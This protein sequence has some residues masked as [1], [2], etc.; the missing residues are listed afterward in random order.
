[1]SRK[2][3]K[4]RDSQPQ[5]AFAEPGRR[6]LP[7]EARTLIA[8]VDND[9][10]IPFF[11][12][13]LQHADDT[14][15]QQGGGKGL[16]IYDE[17]ERDTHASAMIAKR[18]KSL[19]AREWEVEPGGERSIDKEAAELVEEMLGALPFD[20]ICEDLLDATLKGYAVSEIVW[21]R[22]GNRIKPERVVTDE[23][24]RFVFDRDWR[25]RML[26][27]SM[28]MEGIALPE[29]KFIVHR[30]GVK[31]NNP[32][33]LGLGHRL[34]W[35]VLFK[36]EGITFWLHFLEKF[37]GP[38][39]VGKTPIGTLSED[40]SKLLNTLN[41]VRTS[42]AITVPIGTDV[43]FL[44]ASRSGSVSY[45]QFLSYWDRQISISTTGETLTTQVGSSGG[46][47]ALGEVH[48]EMLDLLV[49][50][51]GDL[52]ADT[53][54][55]QLV[56]WIVDYNLPGA[57]VPSVWRIRPKNEKAEAETR[58]VK[59]GAAEA[60]DKA[61]R[62]VVTAAARFEDDAV[63]RDYIVS[64]EVTDHLSD[65][66][67]D[68][69][70]EARHAFSGGAA[71]APS[72]V[73]RDDSPTFSAARLKKK[74]LK[75][76]H[77][78]FADPGGPVEQITD[79]ALAAA[80]SHF[81]RRVAAVRRVVED[82]AGLDN[83]EEAWSAAAAGI[84]ELAAQWTPDAL[85]HQLSLAM[86]VAA[87]EG[88]EAVF[89]DADDQDAD[90]TG[91]EVIRQEFREQ[92][93]FLT[94][95]RGKPTQTWTDARYGDHDRAFTVA[96]VTDMAMLEEFQAAVIEGAR[97]YDIKP[98]A[99][100]FDRLVEKYGWSYNGGRNWRIR[101]IFE[102]NIR[103]S[104]MAG[105]LRQ[106]RDPDVVR[107]MPFWEYVHAE[108]RVPKNPR[109]EHVAWNGLVLDWDDPWWNR[110]FPPNDW[111]CSCGVRNLTRGQLRRMGKDGPDKAPEDVTRPYTHQA[112]GETVQLPEGIGFGWDYMP[113]DTWERGLVPS[114]LLDEG[115]GLKPDGRQGVQIDTPEPLDDLVSRA[116]PFQGQPAAEGLTDEAYVQAFLDPFG[117]QIGE[118]VLWED[119]TGT[120]LPISDQL[121]RDRNGAWKIGK[122]DR[123][124]FT[125]LFAE[126]LMDPDEI[127]VGVARKPDPIDPTVEELL[128]DRRYIRV[129]PDYGLLI[130]FQIGRRWWEGIT[131]YLPQDRKGRPKIADI[132]KRRGGKLIWKRK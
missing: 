74:D 23:Q 35:P 110:H 15:I 94:Q 21:Q 28:M 20:R 61:I 71:D 22:D 34:F 7:S 26:T 55:E 48:Q 17:I 75:Q 37:A 129:D 47:R 38:T 86:E 51:D 113:G 6:N 131:A 65:R 27:W 58:K 18:K 81:N 114:A 57:A 79:Q 62:A 56:S 105:R 95:K 46:N 100:E 14:L 72:N 127:W 53:L 29:R 64:F 85:A 112:T 106:M 68:A 125:P 30:V 1:M 90:F 82:A 59:A 116:R 11:T 96:G 73:Q 44:E 31:G 122:R 52:L 126:A 9:I 107:V 41:T 108:T 103:T 8:G 70:V 132:D 45:E 99:A 19:V 101:T 24:R 69:L 83:E 2:K 87:L 4:S 111:Q 118:A 43:E 54:R 32:Y 89:A 40:Q 104:Y 119:P 128:I 36:R 25:P 115:G 66:T 16:K 98:F 80:E 120:R 97:T 63:A 92:I 67:I 91:A 121:F 84:L 60:T 3:R 50:S 93:D 124:R 130:V 123:A 12:G 5:A 109:E 49:D 88:R 76:R 78:C 102:T 42:S 39:V 117:A 33:G 77:V 13:V 10:T